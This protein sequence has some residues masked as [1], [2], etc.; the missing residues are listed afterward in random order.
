MDKVILMHTVAPVQP[1]VFLTCRCPLSFAHL[2]FYT[3]LLP[4]TLETHALRSFH[5]EGVMD[6][7]VNHSSQWSLCLFRSLFTCL[8][9]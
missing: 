2:V 4:N 7:C 1:P 5:S 8:T 6:I 9:F 3:G